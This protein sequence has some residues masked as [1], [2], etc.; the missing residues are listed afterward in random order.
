MKSI[1]TILT[2]SCALVANGQTN[3]IDIEIFNS[4]SDTLLVYVTESKTGS[5]SDNGDNLFTP[6]TLFPGKALSKKEVKV[7]RYS[8]IKTWGEFVKKGGKTETIQEIVQ[9]ETKKFNKTLS[10]SLDASNQKDIVVLSTVANKY[11]YNPKLFYDTKDLSPKPIDGLFNQYLGS[12][13]AYREVGDS[14]KIERRI[15]PSM[16]NTI[17]RV[18]YG[19]QTNTDEFLISGVTNQEANG[20]IP[21]F[22]ELGVSLGINNTYQVRLSYRGIGVIDWE[23]HNK[24][25]IDKA[26]FKLSDTTLYVVGALREKFPELK[27]DIIDRAFVFDGIFAEVVKM[28]RLT[29]NNNVNASTFFNN[30]GNFTKESKSL[31]SEAFGSSYIGYWS[32]NTVDLTGALDLA[33]YVYAKMRLNELQIQ[34]NTVALNDFSKL[35]ET[36]PTL[37]NLKSKSEIEDYYKT[38]NAELMKNNKIDKTLDLKLENELKKKDNLKLEEILNPN[39]IMELEMKFKRNEKQ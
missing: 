34:N 32:T 5:M 37:P 10:V 36:N 8:V 16:I 26:F 9:K 23:N 24:V 35:R 12:I 27:L 31:S 15:F 20:N 38:K 11:K 17:D 22:G 2:L 25:D 39:T 4:T 13:I 30:K 33:S 1:F 3:K 21:M 19:T 7:T 29:I 6:E 14:I 28:N 18:H